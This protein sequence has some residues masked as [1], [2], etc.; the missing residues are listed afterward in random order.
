VTKSGAFVE[1]AQDQE[2]FDIFRIKIHLAAPDGTISQTFPVSTRGDVFYDNV[3]F[4]SFTSGFLLATSNTDNTISN[5]IY[6][7]SG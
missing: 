5:I 3:V 2:Y 6:A 7:D 4:L 1:I